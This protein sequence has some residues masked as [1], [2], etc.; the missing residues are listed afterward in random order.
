[1]YRG[2]GGGGGGDDD[3]DD[4]AAAAAAAAAAIHSNSWDAASTA[5]GSTITKPATMVDP[6]A[7]LGQE[8]IEGVPVTRLEAQ[9]LRML[10]EDDSYD[11][12]QAVKSRAGIAPEEMELVDGI[13]MLPTETELLEML[14]QGK[15][16]VFRTMARARA[17]SLTSGAVPLVTMVP[18]DAGPALNETTSRASGASALDQQLLLVSSGHGFGF[19]APEPS[20]VPLST[21]VQQEAAL[22]P[23]PP[24]VS[25]GHGIGVDAPEPSYVP[26]SATVQQEAALYPQPPPVS[27]GHGIGVDAPEPSYVPLS[28]TVQQETALYPQPPPVSSGHG[29]GFDA[30]V[31]HTTILSQAVGE[32]TFIGFEGSGANENAV[33]FAELELESSDI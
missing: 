27:S 7:A 2:G 21:M 32:I 25:S 24:P 10:S 16:E 12:L 26:L 23:Q 1:V 5:T 28:A 30:P 18:Q 33:S 3:D 31:E 20:Y 15:Q 22:Y 9:M 29:I 14:P 11:W 13:L 6:A 19:D 17:S 4:D 8:T